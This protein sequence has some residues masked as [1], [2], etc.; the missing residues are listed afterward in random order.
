MHAE[1]R[2]DCR[3]S[4]FEGGRDYSG[5]CK[6]LCYEESLCPAVLPVGGGGGL[7][8]RRSGIRVWGQLSGCRGICCFLGRSRRA[9][10]LQGIIIKLCVS[11]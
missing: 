7:V 9:T 11:L 5:G 2:W 8:G 6:E 1:F 3:S 4:R 10:A